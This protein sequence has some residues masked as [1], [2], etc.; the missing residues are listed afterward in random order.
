MSA[1]M[2]TPACWTLK[3]QGCVGSG[4]QS[5]SG[6]TM[7][8][9]IGLVLTAVVLLSGCG[10]VSPD[11]QPTTTTSTSTSTTSTTTKPSPTKSLPLNYLGWCGCV[12]LGIGEQRVVPLSMELVA[13]DLMLLKGCLLYTSDA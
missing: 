8:R 13:S 12:V 2:N 1:R 7:K 10:T 9:S 6:G 3:Q 5:N 4:A 11:A